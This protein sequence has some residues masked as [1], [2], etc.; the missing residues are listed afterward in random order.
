MC[1]GWGP[2]GLGGRRDGSAVTEGAKTPFS[3]GEGERSHRFSMRN[4]FRKW[5]GGDLRPMQCQMG[6]HAGGLP[7]EDRETDCSF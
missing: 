7:E 6:S 5:E 4:S 2:V 3:V 1:R